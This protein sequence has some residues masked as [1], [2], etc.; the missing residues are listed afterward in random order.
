[1]RW[2]VALLVFST[3]AWS[4]P[5]VLEGGCSGMRLVKRGAD[6][7]FVC[8]GP[9]DWMIVKDW[10]RLCQ[11]TSAVRKASGDILVRCVG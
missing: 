6:L 2:L 11:R 4:A 7:V 10:F 5:F 3:P 8:P 9:T 1:M